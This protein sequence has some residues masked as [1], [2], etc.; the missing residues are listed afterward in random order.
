M[1]KKHERPVGLFT[2]VQVMGMCAIGIVLVTMAVCAVS[3]IG[4]LA[5]VPNYLLMERLNLMDTPLWMQLLPILAGAGAGACLLWLLVEFVLMCG[6]VRRETAFT[7]VNAR[8]LGRIALAFFLGG[9]LLIPCGGLIM[10]VLLLGMRS[11]SAPVWG[12]LPT[13][14]AWAAALM[15]RAI[16]VL[17]RRAVDMQTEADLTV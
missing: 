3:L 12:G 14:A 6:R 11:M 17:L 1:S 16:Q 2:L 5:S 4:N 9:V 15:V 7:A 13:F 8:A 10:D